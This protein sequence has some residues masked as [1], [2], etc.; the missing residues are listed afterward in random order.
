MLRLLDNKLQLEKMIDISDYNGELL[1]H[2]QPTP[3]VIHTLSTPPRLLQLSGTSRLES[4]RL[5]GWRL[6]QSL[7]GCIAPAIRQKDSLN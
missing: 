2:A 3:G 6:S 4:Q 1:S 7:H 5:P